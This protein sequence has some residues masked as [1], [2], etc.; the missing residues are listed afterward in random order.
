VTLSVL[1][2]LNNIW[3][4]GLSF[5]VADSGSGIPTFNEQYIVWFY[6]GGLLANDSTVGV[7]SAFVTSNHQSSMTIGAKATPQNRWRSGQIAG[8]EVH[9]Q[10]QRI[11]NSGAFLEPPQTLGPVTWDPS[12]QLQVLL[13]IW[14][15]TGG[16][17]GGFTDADRALLQSVFSAVTAD[18]RNAP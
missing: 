6:T 14:Q 1:G 5:D 8:G 12:L 9:L 7:A 17:G 15:S 13:Q 10:I 18:V 3:G 16:G 11:D 2:P 4:P